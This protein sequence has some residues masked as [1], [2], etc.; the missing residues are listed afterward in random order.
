M[1]SP[2]FWTWLLCS[3][4]LVP[5]CI[6]NPQPEDPD[7]EPDNGGAGGSVVSNQGGMSSQAQGGWIASDGGWVGTSGGSLVNFGGASINLGGAT[8]EAGASGTSRGGETAD[9][10]GGAGVGGSAAGGAPGPGG[11]SSGGSTVAAGAGGAS[12]GG[13]G[14]GGAPAGGSGAGGASSGGSNAGGAPA[15]GSGAGGAGGADRCDVGVYDPSAPPQ[16]LQIN[17]SPQ[18][19]DPSAIEVDGT[20]YLFSTSMFAWTSSNLTSWQ[21]G[22][23][24][25]GI[26][27]WMSSAISGITDLWAP[28]VSYFGGQY[29]LYFAGSSFGKNTSCIGHA[30]RAS[31]SAGSWTVDDSPTICSNI[32]DYP[33]QNVNWNAIDPNVIIDTDGNPWMDFGSF[34]SGIQLIE[35]DQSGKRVG[36]TVTN[37]ANRGGPGIEGPAIVY[38]CHYYYLFT[39]WDTCCQGASS[40]YNIRVVRSENVDGPYVDQAGTPALNGGGTLI[41]QSDASWAGP[42]GQSVMFTS[43]NKAYLVYHAYA[44]PNGDHHLRLAELVWDSDGWPVPVGP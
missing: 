6:L 19:H 34:W 17:N 5:S 2:W 10:A 25:F 30:T 35:L 23:P 13:S 40:T 7:D 27:A 32:S 9:P 33:E 39:S 11:A 29:H 28:D 8:A 12:S 1:R 22:A 42:G 36:S 26:P 20:Y 15:G 4:Q 41:A 18:A 3:A 43:D 37:I 16:V 31:M 21:G 44:K 14:A 38:R 24:A